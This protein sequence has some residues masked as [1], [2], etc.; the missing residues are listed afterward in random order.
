M[1]NVTSPTRSAPPP[2]PVPGRE[3]APRPPSIDI[4]GLL[5]SAR[6]DRSYA[7]F[8]EVWRKLKRASGP[9]P[10]T[11]VNIALLGTSTLDHV[12]PYL[13]VHALLA[14]FS[15]TIYVAPYN[16][17]RQEILN[18]SSGL[19]AHCRPNTS[20]IVF[21][22][23]EPLD[24]LAELY[25]FPVGQEAAR[26]QRAREVVDGIVSDVEQLLA[27]STARVVVHDFAPPTH[28]LLGILDSKEPYGCNALIRDINQQLE[29]RLRPLDRAFLMPLSTALARAGRDVAS[30][31]KRRFLARIVL[32]RAALPRVCEAWERYLCAFFVP[33]RKVLVLDLDNTLWGGVIGEDG[34]GGIKL[35]DDAPGNCYKALQQVAQ[36]LSRRGVVLAVCSK[37][38]AEDALAAIQSHPG[39]VLREDAF[40]A[41]RCN[42]Q[43]KSLNI[44]EIAAELSLG[45]DS[46]VFVDDN[47][48]ER[49][50]VREAL[51][52]VLVVDLPS[53]PALYA[54]TLASLT[55]FETPHLT[56]EDRARGQLY[57]QRRQTE[58][59]RSQCE[60]LDEFYLSLQTVL[61]L[62]PVDAMSSGRSA[63]LLQRT[64]QF[65]MT[66]RRHS[67]ADLERM[68]TDG[69]FHLLAIS[70]QDRFGD[71]GQ[72]GLVLLEMQDSDAIIESFVLSCRVLGRG[73]EQAILGTV[74]ELARSQGAHRLIGQL[75]YSKKNTPARELYPASGLQILT[76]MPEGIDYAYDLSLPG[77][78]IP[79]WIHIDALL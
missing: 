48:V 33:A 22:A 64:N 72:V 50:K 49:A 35:G 68:R 62:R 20:S 45:L 21:L 18:P 65:N 47:A 19:H 43:E 10:G 1:D 26:R 8:Y 61:T 6:A 16:Q 74:A 32:D 70:L 73:V 36:Q 41:I 53:D 46:F 11:A 12:T 39:M 59:L 71:Q 24:L 2:E 52:E 79:A 30:P 56:A 15:P 14:G 69:R 38:N 25:D 54:Q 5:A 57:V 77:P 34:I 9:L 27:R 37:N 66:T 42:W 78:T 31:D 13:T 44:R 40:A 51:P 4:D 28:P 75:R 58:A 17:I 3:E 29:E 63:Q 60:S 67:E 55:C 7:N 23:Y 76:E